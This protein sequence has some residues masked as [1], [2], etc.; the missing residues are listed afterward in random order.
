MAPPAVRVALV[1]RD[2]LAMSA[3]VA[4]R[5]AK[6]AKVTI[7]AMVVVSSTTQM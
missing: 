2:M 6:V 3:G 5:V 4:A 7:A 1:E